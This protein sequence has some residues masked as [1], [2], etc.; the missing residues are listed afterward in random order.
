MHTSDGTNAV[1]HADNHAGLA[2]TTSSQKCME[3]TDSNAL[4]AIKAISTKNETEYYTY[5]D[6]YHAQN[7]NL[8][9]TSENELFRLHAGKTGFDD[10]YRAHF[11][12]ELVKSITEG[13]SSSR[14]YFT[15]TSMEKIMKKLL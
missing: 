13:W 4:A 10:C 7:D 1:T 6:G 15:P 9:D 12:D 14:H 8:S 3:I 5:V 11:L 2:F